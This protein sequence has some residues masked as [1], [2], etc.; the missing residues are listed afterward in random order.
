[1]IS[2]FCSRWRLLRAVLVIWVVGSLLAS[3]I[4]L[5][6][7]PS[8]DLYNTLTRTELESSQ[9]WLQVHGDK[10]KFVFFKQLQGAG[11]NNQ[12]QEILLYH[13]L[14]LS[15][16]RTYVY[17]PLVWRP[18]GEK[19]T[20]PLSAF[21]RGPIE[22]SISEAAFDSVCPPGQVTHITLGTVGFQDLW[23]HAKNSLSRDDRCIYVDDHILNWRYLASPAIHDIWPSFNQY[24]HDHFAWSNPVLKIVRRTQAKLR[25]RPGP[26]SLHGEPYMALHFRRGD[27]EEHCQV[28]ANDRMGFTTWSTLPLLSDSIQPPALNT[29]NISSVTEHCYP[30]LERL[31]AIID[32]QAIARPHLRTLH[33]LH[34]GTWDHPLVYWQKLQ[35][36]RALRDTSRARAAGWPENKPLAIRVVHS[37]MLQ[38]AWGEGDMA[39]AA[40]VEIARRADVFIGNGY[41]SLSS[42]IAALRLGADAGRKEDIVFM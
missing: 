14:A 29:A 20:V 18:R 30:T 16:S 28:L 8:Y 33:V 41:S 19:S 40:D 42:Q 9:K 13:H 27:F 39:V 21:L 32:A 35:L 6:T 26:H 4:F 25:L 2:F 38:L 17:Q 15:A 31:L 11:F 23:N 10:R 22:G 34:D 12:V 7:R 5:K 37:G 24:L 3:Y 36:E 1:M